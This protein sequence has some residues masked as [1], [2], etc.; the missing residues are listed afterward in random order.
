MHLSYSLLL[1]SVCA[2]V[3]AQQQPGEDYVLKQTNLTDLID[4]LAPDLIKSSLAII[5]DYA[6][7]ET[8]PVTREMKQ[9]P[10]FR[11]GFKWSAADWHNDEKTTFWRPQGISTISD[12]DAEVYQGNT[13]ILA[14]SWVDVRNATG[15][16]L[17]G[18]L[19]VRVSFV[20]KGSADLGV[21]NKAYQHVLLVEPFM[22]DDGKPNYR[23]L[24]NIK[25]GGM[26][27]RG[28][29]LFITDAELGVRVFDVERLFIVKEGEHVGR[30][31]KGNWAAG[32][33]KYIMPQA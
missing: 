4:D 32:L 11:K 22:D 27:W 20:R 1:F 14:A 2:P 24:V 13:E 17:S 10:W 23:A 5:L 19:G 15:N 29:W 28:R 31:R 8:L 9:V 7:F 16:A 18:G 12:S 25:S 26:V 30:D 33:Y 21:A 6:P 3:L